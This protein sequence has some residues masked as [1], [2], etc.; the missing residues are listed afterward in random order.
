MDQIWPEPI[1]DVEPSLAYEHDRSKKFLRIDMVT[2][3]DGAFTIDGRAKG[4]SGSPDRRVFNA[5]RSLADVILVGANT[6]RIENYK[7]VNFDESVQAVRKG[8]GQE[9]LAPI[10]LCSRSL[11][12]DFT[13]PLFVEAK[14]KTIIF[15]T[16]SSADK[17][18]KHND[19][20]EIISC[21]ED[22]V[23]L[24]QAVNTLIQRGL[25]SILCEGGP[26][27]NADL[28]KEDLVDELCLSISPQIVQGDDPSIFN[29]PVL[30]TPASSVPT[31]IFKEEDFIFL[32][33]AL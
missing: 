20:A 9:A 14:E 21:G 11:D 7:P 30:S 8:R 15:T 27:L 22:D 6:A 25:T 10:A 24:N 26:K 28:L 18:K 31:H 2:S 29:G 1:S 17:G 33:L 12:F 19:V 32:R 13:S 4:L 16:S 5:M 23:D 3:I